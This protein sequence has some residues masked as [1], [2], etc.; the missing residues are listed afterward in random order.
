MTIFLILAIALAVAWLL[1][2]M[3]F[4]VASTTIHLLIVLALLSV[5]LHLARGSSS[6]SK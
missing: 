3:L 1:G 2:F 4:H 6:P 5:A